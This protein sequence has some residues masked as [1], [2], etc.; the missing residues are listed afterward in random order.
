MNEEPIQR[1]LYWRQSIGRLLCIW[2]FAGM[3]LSMLLN[4]LYFVLGIPLPPIIFFLFSLIY[5][6][7]STL[8]GLWC[9]DSFTR[10]RLVPSS[11][12]GS[13]FVLAASIIFLFFAIV[14]I[15]IGFQ[16]L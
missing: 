5:L 4:S 16:R 2:F 3:P 11:L 12:V 15:V 14:F 13:L 6:S 1:Q 7:G 9:L 10:K 8:A